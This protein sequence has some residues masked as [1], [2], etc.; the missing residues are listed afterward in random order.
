M[1]FL[2][3]VLGAAL[4]YY[5][6]EYLAQQREREGASERRRVLREAFTPNNKQRKP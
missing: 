1:K 2:A 5:G 3:T 6:A 4:G